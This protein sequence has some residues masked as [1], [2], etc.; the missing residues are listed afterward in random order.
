MSYGIASGLDL[1]ILAREHRWLR[2]VECL[3]NDTNVA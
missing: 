1:S 3:Q 2:E